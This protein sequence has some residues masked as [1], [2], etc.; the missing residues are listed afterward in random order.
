MFKIGLDGQC[1]SVWDWPLRLSC[2]S[3]FN[4]PVLICII[5]GW[6]IKSLQ[7]WAESESV[8]L[9]CSHPS[10]LLQPSCLAYVFK[11]ILWAN[12]IFFLLLAIICFSNTYWH[13]YFLVVRNVFMLQTKWLPLSLSQEQW[14][15]ISFWL[16]SFFFNH[17]T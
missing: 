13:N 5:M 2:Q 7:N 14:V 8:W 4:I 10:D 17:F 6:D 15:C 3:V 16:K 12:C 9:W 1:V 11:L